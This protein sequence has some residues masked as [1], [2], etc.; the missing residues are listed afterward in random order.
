MQGSTGTIENE[1]KLG[2]KQGLDDKVGC[3]NACVGHIIYAKKL[4]ENQVRFW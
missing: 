4:I 1:K 2:Q 3:L